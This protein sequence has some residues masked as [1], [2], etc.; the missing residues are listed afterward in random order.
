MLF[1]WYR[2]GDKSKEVG[3][4]WSQVYAGTISCEYD[5]VNLL[6]S[7]EN[8]EMSGLAGNTSCRLDTWKLEIQ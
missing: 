8:V 4:V 7:R 1:P 2:F 5:L 3:R 6:M